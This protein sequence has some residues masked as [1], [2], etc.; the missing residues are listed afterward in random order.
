M[1]FTIFIPDAQVR[2]VTTNRYT[3]ERTLAAVYAH[4]IINRDCWEPSMKGLRLAL[5]TSNRNSFIYVFTDAP[6]R[7]YRDSPYIMDLCQKKQTQVQSE[8]E[9]LI[10]YSHISIN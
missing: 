5:E 6:A 7:D 9:Y 8:H 2:A 4:N 10:N 3:F 1:I